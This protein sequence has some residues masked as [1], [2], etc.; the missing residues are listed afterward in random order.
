MKITIDDDALSKL[1]IT[2]EE[3]LLW[4][5]LMK[6]SNLA[7]LRESLLNKNLI[8]VDNEPTLFSE[9]ESL[10][11]EEKLLCDQAVILDP[12]QKELLSSVLIDS[13]GKNIRDDFFIKVAKGMRELFPEGKKPGTPYYWRDSVFTIV[14][15]LKNLKKKYKAEFTEQEALD[16][17]KNYVESF[18]G[19]Y[20][21]MQLLKY[22]IYKMDGSEM[23]SD[24]MSYIA[25]KGQADNINSDNWQTR[26]V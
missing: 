22:F 13:N 7:Q 12:H 3:F 19:D 17:T 20:Q 2:M 14:D 4:Y 6:K 18:N 1:D 15:R 25:N 11:A 5:L 9:N 26:L 24:F 21:Y 10:S 8:T 16:A 23:R